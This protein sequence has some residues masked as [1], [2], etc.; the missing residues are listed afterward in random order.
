MQFALHGPTLTLRPPVAADA[1]VLLALGVGRRRSRAG[2]RGGRTTTIER[3]AGVHR[4]PAGAPRA[5][6]ADRPADRP[7]RARADRRHGLSELRARDRR[8]MVGTWFG[9]RVLGHRRQHARSKAIVAHLAFELLG[10]E[11]L[12]AYSNPD[13]GR[14]TRALRG[15]AS[16]TRACCGPGTVTATSTST[17]T[18]S[19]CCAP[20]G[21]AARWRRCPC[22]SRARCRRRSAS[23]RPQSRCV[24]PGEAADRE[25]DAEREPERDHDD[26]TDEVAEPP[27]R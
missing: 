22:G 7:P 2:S 25:E 27:S 26:V 12:G 21:R 23:D 9:P 14:S 19:G 6:R 17:S 16:P 24:A 10:I 4:G 8:A 3:A 5:R 15:S 13:N 18:S 11:R 20:N 1:D